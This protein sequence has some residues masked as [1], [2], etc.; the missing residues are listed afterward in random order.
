MRQHRAADGSDQKQP[1]FIT[2]RLAKAFA[3][4]RLAERR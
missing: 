3:T 2:K 1:F 4:G